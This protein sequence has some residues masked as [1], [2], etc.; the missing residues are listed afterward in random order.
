MTGENQCGEKPNINTG[1]LDH[2]DSN[3]DYIKNSIECMLR[4]LSVSSINRVSEVHL[5]SLE[6]KTVEDYV[7]L[8]KAHVK[9][10]RKELLTK[11]TL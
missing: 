4:H 6:M 9:N 1:L 11:E 7:K 3:L 2:L 10:L 8:S 5:L